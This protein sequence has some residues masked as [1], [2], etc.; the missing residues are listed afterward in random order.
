MQVG[1]TWSTVHVL[2]ELSTFYL[3]IFHAGVIEPSPELFLELLLYLDE[4][5]PGCSLFQRADW[6]WF[7]GSR[8]CPHGFFLSFVADCFFFSSNE[9]PESD[10][11]GI[12]LCSSVK[13]GF[14]QQLQLLFGF[15]SPVLD[16][17]TSTLL[18]DKTLQHHIRIKFI[19]INY[20]Y[21]K[22]NIIFQGDKI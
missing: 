13:M 16:N 21:K 5:E 6:N 19:S 7:S 20:K 18:T 2:Y 22:Y 9:A 8:Q 14:T 3:G 15:L 11:I 10:K 1:K 4:F 12:L 17:S